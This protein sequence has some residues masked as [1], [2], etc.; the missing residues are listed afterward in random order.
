[1]HA[2]VNGV[3]FC[4]MIRI[5]KLVMSIDAYGFCWI[6]GICETSFALWVPFVTS[7][8]YTML[9]AFGVSFCWIIG[10]VRL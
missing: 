5:V 4:L 10:I 2:F 9:T 3:S 7:R 6:V 8:L 1:V